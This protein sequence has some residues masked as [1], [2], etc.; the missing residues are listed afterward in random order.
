MKFIKKIEYVHGSYRGYLNGFV[1]TSLFGTREETQDQLDYLEEILNK[2]DESIIK[3]FFSSG[4]ERVQ[5]LLKNPSDLIESLDFNQYP[6]KREDFFNSLRN[7]LNE[8]ISFK[9][10]FSYSKLFL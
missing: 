2:Y 8:N 3:Q 7:K 4:K 9:K 6:E 1:A 5:E 10:F